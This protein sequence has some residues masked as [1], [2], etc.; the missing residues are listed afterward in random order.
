MTE[1][2]TLKDFEKRIKTLEMH[3]FYNELKAEAIKWRKKSMKMSASDINFQTWDDFFNITEA[4]LIQ[5]E[6]RKE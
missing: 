4:D 3:R 6:G 1:L 2:K 5:S